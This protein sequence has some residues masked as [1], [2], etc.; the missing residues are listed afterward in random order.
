MRT[1]IIGG[2]GSGKSA[3]A[4][5]HVCRLAGRRIY[6]AT[7]T[8]RDDES[9]L[10]IARHRLQRADSGFETLERGLGLADAEIPEGSSVLL[11]DLSNLLANEMFMPA[12]GD[13]RSVREGLS[14]LEAVS[15]HLTVVSNELFSDGRRYEGD[16][17]RYME[18]LAELNRELAQRADLVV[19]V[20]CG[21]PNVLKGSLP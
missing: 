12:G 9:L 14:H 21:L 17:L 10:R 4:E 16:T 19:E 13:V 15:R 6:L 2:A 1:L 11:E 5:A 20:V 3:F 7:M 18:Q 8:A